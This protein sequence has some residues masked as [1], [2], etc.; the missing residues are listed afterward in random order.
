MNYYENSVFDLIGIDNQSGL[1]RW[2][3]GTRGLSGR[4]ALIDY[5]VLVFQNGAFLT[6]LVGVQPTTGKNLWE[7]REDNII[8]N[9]IVI[10]G[11]LYALTDEPAII[12]VDAPTGQDV[13]QM[14]FTGGP[15]DIKHSPEYFLLTDGP[16]VFVYF[17]DSQELIAFA[18]R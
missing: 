10:S 15:L 11:T 17:H 4:P 2:T 18:H 9:F 13:G 5:E 16:N 12:A 3:M 6:S 14:T 1:I 8:S 7:T